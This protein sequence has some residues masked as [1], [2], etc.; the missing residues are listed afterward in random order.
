MSLLDQIRQHLGDEALVEW[1]RNNVDL[2][3]E[4]HESS[5]LADPHLAALRFDCYDSMLFYEEL[6]KLK[7]HDAYVVYRDGRFLS[8]WTGSCWINR[9]RNPLEQLD[10]YERRAIAAIKS[11]QL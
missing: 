5:S 6:D 3:V 8:I 4:P 1:D 10:D 11:R 9:K 7:H 2:D